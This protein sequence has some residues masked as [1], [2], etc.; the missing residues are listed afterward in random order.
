MR[1][2]QLEIGQKRK[3]QTNQNHLTTII[4]YKFKSPSSSIDK[5]VGNG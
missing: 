4:L 3:P 5:P 2:L 1:N